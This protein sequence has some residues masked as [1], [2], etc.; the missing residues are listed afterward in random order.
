MEA[1][2]LVGEE[3][4]RWVAFGN[5]GHLRGSPHPTNTVIPSKEGI[6]K[7]RTPE[8]AGIKK[9]DRI[10]IPVYTGMTLGSENYAKISRPAWAMGLAP[11]CHVQHRSGYV[12]R[13][14]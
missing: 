9:D 6:Q 4:W 14:V 10:W 12:T 1:S 2:S 13:I 11:A 8:H 3:V 5:N 7:R